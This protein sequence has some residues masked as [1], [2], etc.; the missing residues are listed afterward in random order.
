M[1]VEG[2]PDRPSADGLDLPATGLTASTAVRLRPGTVHAPQPCRSACSVSASCLARLRGRRCV[3][4]PGC[5]RAASPD[6]PRPLYEVVPRMSWPAA[7]SGLGD[8]VRQPV[9]DER[10]LRLAWWRLPRSG[11]RFSSSRSSTCS[12]RRRRS[13]PSARACDTSHRHGRR[14]TGSRSR[15]RPRR[16]P[17]RALEEVDGNRAPPATC[18]FGV[19][20]QRE[21]RVLQSPEAARGRG[22]SACVSTA[23]PAGLCPTAMV[24]LRSMSARR[25]SADPAVVTLDEIRR[26]SATVARSGA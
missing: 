8:V 26:G 21:A 24:R 10:L 18:Q 14:A 4:R 13:R 25:A 11:P 22:W 15:S 12:N 9:A 16:R 23:G 19:E 5:L 17:Q 1:P 2:R 3:F 20:R 7:C 6:E